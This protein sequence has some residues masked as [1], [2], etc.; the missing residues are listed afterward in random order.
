MVT[1][2]IPFN[3]V[4][5]LGSAHVNSSDS[6]PYY[7]I[8]A[9]RKKIQIPEQAR[10]FRSTRNEI[11]S[12]VTGAVQSDRFDANAKELERFLIGKCS[13]CLVGN[14]FFFFHPFPIILWARHP[15]LACSSDFLRWFTILIIIVLMA[16]SARNEKL[17]V[18]E[19][20]IE[21]LA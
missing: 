1:K 21:R 19:D 8:V 2:R 10:N 3:S 17:V 18:Y 9:C 20:R 12:R 11:V 7:N 4:T 6:F 15:K 14:R 13:V 5:N 16:W